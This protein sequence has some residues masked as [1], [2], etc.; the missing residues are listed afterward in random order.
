MNVDENPESGT[1]T[2]EPE[3]QWFTIPT[4]DDYVKHGIL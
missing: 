4:M 1:G 3:R 2:V